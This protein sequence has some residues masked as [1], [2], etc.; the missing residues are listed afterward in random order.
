MRIL[1]IL[2]LASLM[3]CQQKANFDKLEFSSGG[4]FSG[5]VTTYSVMPDGKVYKRSSISKEE[6]EVG[7]MS[8]EELDEILQ[9]TKAL[10]GFFTTAHEPGSINRSITFHS[11]DIKYQCVWTPQIPALS[12]PDMVYHYFI[13][14]IS[15]P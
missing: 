12:A 2:L 4:G 15:K 10:A 14:T 6:V 7:R 13:Q 1:M 5:E 3:S 11:G 8:A 9:L